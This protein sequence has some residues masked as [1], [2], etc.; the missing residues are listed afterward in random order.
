MIENTPDYIRGR[1][2]QFNPKNKFIKNERVREHM[3]GIDDWGEIN[4]ATQF[5]E[6]HAKGIVN[7]VTSPDLGMWYSMNPYQGCE[8]GCIYCYARNAHE[9]WGYSAGLDFERKI[10]VKKN[11]P[12]LFRKFLMN[13]RWEP[14]PI[15]VSGNTDCYQPAE[16]IY[17]L[18]RQF[19]EIALEFGQPIAMITKN[20]GILRDKDILEKMAKRNLVQ[21]YVSFTTMNEDLRRVMEPRTTTAKQR[22]RILQELSEVGVRM[23]V[24]TAPI[25]PGLNDHELPA[26]LKAASEAGASSAGYTYTAITTWPVEGFM[27]RS[28]ITTSPI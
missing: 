6:D 26:L 8:H 10:I 19:L 3:E 16:K 5:L 23:G 2:S 24:M 22:L 17:R 11:A 25:I 15:S 13:P 7:K 27:E 9:Y 14:L 4:E 12:E 18:T 28:T 21:V 1:G 20:A